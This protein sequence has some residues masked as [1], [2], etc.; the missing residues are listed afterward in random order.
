MAK[1]GG[2]GLQFNFSPTDGG[3]ELGAGGSGGG[4]RAPRRGVG[5]CYQVEA[6]MWP[7]YSKMS[8]N[9]PDKIKPFGTLVDFGATHLGHYQTFLCGHHLGTFGTLRKAYARVFFIFV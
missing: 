4:K 9:V 3:T 2:G 7:K 6:F 1:R 8:N 5:P